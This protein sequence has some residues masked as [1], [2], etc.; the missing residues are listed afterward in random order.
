MKLLIFSF[1]LLMSLSK[2]VKIFL[3]GG[4]L[5]DNNFELFNAIANSTS[6]KPSPNNCTTDWDTTTC[7]RIAVIVS[8]A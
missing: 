8:A 1:I 2:S 5:N 6:R 4:A 7:P 3:I